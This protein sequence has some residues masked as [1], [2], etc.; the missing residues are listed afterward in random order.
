M[1]LRYFA[2]GKASGVGVD[3]PGWHVWTIRGEGC[4]LVG[5]RTRGEALEAAGLRE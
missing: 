5:P 2:R 3:M 4:A 1:T